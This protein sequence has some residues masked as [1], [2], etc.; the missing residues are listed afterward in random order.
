MSATA[1]GR[2]E[3]P[4]V[5]SADPANVLTEDDEKRRLEEEARVKEED[6]VKLSGYK[7]VFF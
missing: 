5:L 1:E 6:K 2:N 4:E 7:F 3:D